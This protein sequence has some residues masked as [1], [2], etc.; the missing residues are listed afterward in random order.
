M[1]VD[2]SNLRY[3]RVESRGRADGDV[4]PHNSSHLSTSNQSTGQ[5]KLKVTGTG[6]LR[7]D[8][9]EDG[10]QLSL[11]GQG[12]CRNLSLRS[13]PSGQGISTYKRREIASSFAKKRTL[14]N[15]L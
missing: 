4:R 14:R 12:R 10:P 1:L 11:W 15:V 7:C 6:D 13:T 5:A 3:G 9:K 8:G 2:N